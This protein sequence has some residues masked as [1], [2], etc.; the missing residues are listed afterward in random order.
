ME[1][2]LRKPRGAEVDLTLRVGSTDEACYREIFD[3]REY[4]VD[5]AVDPEAIVDAGAN[6]GLAAVFFAMRFPSARILA[7]EPEDANFELLLKNVERYPNITPIQAALWNRDESVVVT[8]PRRGAWAFRTRGASD[9]DDLEVAGNVVGLSMETL[10]HAHGLSKIDLLKIDI[11]GAEKPVFESSA[12]WLDRVGMICI[13]LHDRFAPGCRE[14]F[15]SAL[16]R[17]GGFVDRWQQR[18]NLFVARSGVRKTFSTITLQPCVDANHNPNASARDHTSFAIPLRMRSDCGIAATML[19][20]NNEAIIADAIRSAIDWV[21]RFLLIDTGITDNS[22]KVVEAIAGEK[23]V[24]RPFAWCNDFALARNF[25]IQAAAEL[26]AI[27]ALTLDTD[28]RVIVNGY[29]D[30]EALRQT[31]ASDDAV[32]AWLVPSRDGSYDK[33]RFIRTRTHLTWKGRTHE[34]LVGANPNQ[35]CV[36]P[37]WKFFEEPK[38]PEQFQHKLLRD[39]AVLKE[40][41]TSIPGNARWWYYLGQ[42]LEQLHRFDEAISAYQRCFDI[43][44]HWPEQAAWACFNMAKCHSHLQQFD[45]AIEACAA[46]LARQPASP[47]LA[48]QAAYCCYQKGLDA[49]AILWA[50]IAIR[51]GHVEGLMAGNERIGFRNLVGWYEGPYDV[52][53]FAHRRL[54]AYHKAAMAEQKYHYAKRLRETGTSSPVRVLQKES[55]NQA[56]ARDTCRQSEGMTPARVRIAVFGTYSSG[57][58]AVAGLLHHLGIVMGK[59]FWGDHYEAHWMSQQLRTWWSEPGLI[60]TVAPGHRIRVL[61]DWVHGMESAAVAPAT[62]AIGLKHP[63]LVLC[64]DD[65]EKAWG[66]ETR[67]IWCHRPLSESIESLQRRGWWPGRE[68]AVQSKLYHC[69]SKFLANKNHLQIE[70]SQ[71]LADPNKIVDQ[72]IEYLTQSPTTAQRSRAVESIRGQ[73]RPT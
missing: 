55:S 65:I 32:H 19:C 7:I 45:L 13:E 40:E 25:A 33:E 11:E 51:L 63:L 34:S 30:I 39:L 3:L 5:F 18:E 27:W 16:T 1:Y 4:H 41:T 12:T 64:C 62:A 31:L 44:E 49:D 73:G 59:Q 24:V 52:L 22:L 29:R 6:V 48:W 20:G 58:S 17:D 66:A 2:A 42:T 57:S 43:R 9:R 72:A 67:Y 61:K 54:G 46:G 71:L 15:E 37:G 68:E 70:Y 69:A 47:D 53:R 60:E 50:E 21:D 14:T 28:E 36:L 35:R 23:L 10:M 38:T 56:E 26:G 8:D